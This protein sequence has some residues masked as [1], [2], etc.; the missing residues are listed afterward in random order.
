MSII[1][2]G[3]GEVGYHLAYRLSQEKKDVVVIDRDPEKIR[4]VQS[5][6]DVQA[7]HG[8]GGSISLLR[9]AG[10]SE[11]EMIIAVTNSDEVNMISCLVAGVQ[12]RVPIKI[13][14]VR[15]PEY[16]YLFPLFDKEH[17][18]IDFVINPDHEVVEMLL[19][20]MEVPGAVEVVD[21][22]E[23]QIR[24]VGLPLSPE[25]PLVG[26]R[27]AEIREMHPQSNILIAAIQKGDS[28]VIPKGHNVLAANDLLFAVMPLKVTREALKIFG[29]N[30]T[31]IKRVMILG[32]GLIGLQLAKS[33]EERGI[34]VKII[35]PNEARCM[36]IAEKC[37]KAI[38]LRGDATYQDI[39]L[40]E[41]VSEMD[42]FI[43]VTEDDEDNV[44]ISLLAKK[45]GTR[46]VMT[47]INKVAYSRL[48]HSI[49]IDVVISPRLAAV[50]KI[51]QFIRRGKVLSVSSLPEENAE[52]FEVIALETSDLVGRPLREIK[53]PKEAI[54]GALVRG[55]EVIIPDGSTVIQPG[56]RVMIFA[57]T[58]AIPEVEKA[59]MVKLEYW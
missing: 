58:T 7:I 8:S 43:A 52:A 57:L 26:K 42:I 24:M 18:D 44:M 36:E 41:N 4:R 34:Q 45:M 40:E 53:F 6:L 14:R 19:K 23:G 50:N 3:A 39:L 47:L 16:S 27:L 5:T 25:S 12:D 21:F 22:A 10:I 1:I 9:Q 13:A 35:E 48:V 59:L 33:L 15:D 56:D 11:A 2:I 51:L 49:G 28:V 37:R 31:A 55:S 54:I 29:N 32:G 38:V 30:Y 17:L 46:R 20:L